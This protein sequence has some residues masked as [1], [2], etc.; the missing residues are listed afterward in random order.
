M[1]PKTRTRMHV[2]VACRFGKK[3]N[4]VRLW[5]TSK[6][7][8]SDSVSQFVYPNKFNIFEGEPCGWAQPA[9]LFAG[10]LLRRASDTVLGA[11][12]RKCGTLPKLTSLVE[13]VLLLNP[14]LFVH[15]EVPRCLCG[16]SPAGLKPVA[17]CNQRPGRDTKNWSTWWSLAPKL[18]GPR[19]QA[20][21]LEGSTGKPF[22]GFVTIFHNNNY[23]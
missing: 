18:R 9:F 5:G 22:Q 10:C 2:H 21:D 19:T 12:N 11:K 17:C 8:G 6:K 14:Q 23:N 20:K 4:L 16:A 3:P 1:L 7:H 13:I 15:F